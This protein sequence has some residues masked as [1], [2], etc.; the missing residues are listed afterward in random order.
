MLKPPLPK[1]TEAERWYLLNEVCHLFTVE[2]QPFDEIVTEGQLA[3]MA[4]IIFRKKKRV[5]IICCTQYGKSL[6]VAMCLVFLTCVEGLEVAVVAPSAEKAKIIMRYYIEHLGDSYLFER[7][8]E[9]ETRLERLK[10]EGS[11]A[12]IK[13]NNGGGVFVVSADQR[14]MKKSIESAMGLGAKVIIMDE[15]CLIQDRTEA[16]IFRMI[17]GKTG[18]QFYCKIGNPFF[19]AAPNSHFKKSWEDESY[20]KIFIDFEQALR[21]GRYNQEFID[22]ARNKPM[23]DILYECVFPDEDVADERGFRQLCFTRNIK[24]G[25]TP[26]ILK[27]IIRKAREQG[28]LQNPLKVGADIAGGGD[29]NVYVLRFGIFACVIGANRSKDT[30]FNVTELTRLQKEWG[31]KWSDVNID[32]IGIGRGVS[33]RMIEKGYDV[34]ATDVSVKAMNSK[35]YFNLKAELYWKL[36]LWIKKPETRLDK[37]PEWTQL[38]WIK[39]KPTTDETIKIEPKEDLVA[40]T[41][42]SPDFAEALML[43][44]N[45][46][47]FIGF[48]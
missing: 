34:C 5:E 2:G 1:L 45:N 42:K 25:V 9:Q 23:F 16:T 14:N 27:E 6:V 26:D 46:K 8:L 7:R 11:K 44:F 12:R 10:Q 28:P 30:M 19:T 17:G 15:A 24:F 31:F 36:G 32:D 37:R 3:I 21:E 47:Q 22:E 13:L 38:T 20:E 29:W 35:T 33:D 48:V 41:K 18:E 39:W 4:Q 40:R 43:T